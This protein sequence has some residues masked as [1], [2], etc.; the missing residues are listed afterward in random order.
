[1]TKTM[2]TLW[3]LRLVAVA[4]VEDNGRRALALPLGLFNLVCLAQRYRIKEML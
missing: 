3:C 1:M 4:D 2:V